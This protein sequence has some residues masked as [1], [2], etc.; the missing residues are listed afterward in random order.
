MSWAGPVLAGPLPPDA[1]FKDIRYLPRTLDD[2]GP[3]QAT[4]ILF[5]SA[6]HP[7]AQDHLRALAS[8][9]TPG[10]VA[11]L[12][13][14]ALSA[15]RQDT[16]MDVAYAGLMAGV[17]FPQGKDFDA[18]WARAL[19]VSHTPTLVLLDAAREVVYRGAPDAAGAGRAAQLMAGKLPPDAPQPWTD[20]QPLDP[21]RLPDPDPALSFHGDI[22]PILR[23]HCVSCHR[24]G[25]GA[26]IALHAYARVAA[27]A[28]MIAEV[29]REER[30]PPWYAHPAHGAFR[31]DRRMPDAERDRLLAWI[32]AGMPEGASES[33]LPAPER[34]DTAAWRIA[35]DIVVAARQHIALPATGFVPYQYVFLPFTASEDTYVE[36]IEI[37]GDQP[38]V[39]HHANLFYTL[40]G[41]NADADRHFLTGMV[42]GGMPSV[43]DEGNAWMIPKGGTLTLQ[44]HHVTTGRPTL[45][46][47]SV[48]LRFPKGPVRKRLYYQNLER[49]DLAIP[50]GAPG[51]AVVDKAVL[52]RDVTGLG[53][54]SHMHLRGRAMTF[55]ARYPDGRDEMLLALPNYSF[56]WQLTYRYPPN[57]VRFPKGTEITCT[58]YYDNSPFNPYNPDPEITVRNGP[59]TIHEMMNGFFVYTHDDETL[60]LD[61]HPATG[62]P[63]SLRAA[64]ASSVSLHAFPALESSKSIDFPTHLP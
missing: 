43:L 5:F 16:V 49:T 52:D 4:A 35:P 23:D 8:L 28:A 39:V 63:V 42:P 9:Q 60:N 1:S 14:L 15:E 21:D 7:G 10:P 29:V 18:R 17:F 32:G 27:N 22:A 37:R 50:P 31:D 46:H 47:L 40:D 55:S 36:A 6:R 38:E 2:L 64:Q 24:P 41:F 61:V 30:M 51:H 58:A 53:L 12:R 59:Q 26:P 44:I 54:F 45:S 3:G 11:G 33:A 13:L 19:G 20:G 56:D 62:H 57:R 34:A 48:G 25:G